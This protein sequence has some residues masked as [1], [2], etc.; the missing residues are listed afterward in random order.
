[1]IKKNLLI[2]FLLS[3][4]TTGYATEKVVITSNNYEPYTSSKKN[5]S[6]FVLDVVREAFKEVG[7]EVIYEFYPWKRCEFYVLKGKAF[8]ATPYLKTAERQKLYDFSDPITHTY[9]R[10]FYNNEKF[11]NGYNWKKMEDFQEFILGGTL[12]YWYIDKFKKAGLTYT[13]S[14]ENKNFMLLIRKRIDFL[15][16]DELAGYNILINNFKEEAHNISVLK[17]PLTIGNTSLLISRKYPKS[18]ELREKF[19]KGLKLIKKKS[20]YKKLLDKYGIPESFAIK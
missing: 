11:P 5:G 10:F 17:N 19:N 7:V 14:T 2:C 8:A 13:L 6:G 1:M 15:V 3:F 18:S 12:G 9:N 20:I 16:I 4:I